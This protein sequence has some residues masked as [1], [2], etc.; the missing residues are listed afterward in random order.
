MLSML[1]RVAII[2]AWI[3]AVQIKGIEW[4]KWHKQLA[5]ELIRNADH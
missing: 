1:L 4:L 2:D 3:F 5:L